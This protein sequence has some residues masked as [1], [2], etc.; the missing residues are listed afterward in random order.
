MPPPGRAEFSVAQFFADGS[1]QYVRRYVGVEAAV[2]AAYHYTHSVGAQVGTTRRVII[3]DGGDLV[4]FEWQ[5][6]AGVVFPSRAQ[7]AALAT[8]P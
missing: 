8:K 1:W 3:T 2:E 6:G 5:F 7:C 4:A